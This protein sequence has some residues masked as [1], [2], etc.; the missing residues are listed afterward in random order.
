[1]AEAQEHFIPS[2]AEDLIEFHPLELADLKSLASNSWLTDGAIRWTIF[3]NLTK[4]KKYPN[5]NLLD[6]VWF[7]SFNR[8]GYHEASRPSFYRSIEDPTKTKAT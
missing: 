8:H 7:D 5:I 6:P 3:A 1:M 2:L 4:F